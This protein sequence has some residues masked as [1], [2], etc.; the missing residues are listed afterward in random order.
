MYFVKPYESY[1]QS[2]KVDAEEERTGEV[3]LSMITKWIK[4]Q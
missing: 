1:P 3:K 2:W 4:M